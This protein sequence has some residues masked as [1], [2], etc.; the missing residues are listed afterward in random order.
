MPVGVA[1]DRRAQR[2]SALSSAAQRRRMLADNPDFNR[3]AAVQVSHAFTTHRAQA[4]DDFFTAVDDL[5]TRDEDAGGSHLGEHGFGSGVYYLYACVSVD[6]LVENLAG[7]GALAAEGLAALVEAL[8]TA[9]PTDS[10]TASPTDPGRPMS[11]PKSA[12]PRR[13]T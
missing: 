1:S 11:A 3:D 12:R 10:R 13:A 6:L 9:T 5:K 2:G 8:A 4:E 7:D